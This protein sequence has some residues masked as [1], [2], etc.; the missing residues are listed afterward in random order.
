M[1]NY[2]KL[3]GIIMNSFE[4]L[5]IQ[6]IIGTTQHYYYYYYELLSNAMHYQEVAGI[7]VNSFE[8]ISI[9]KTANEF[10]LNSYG[11]FMN[12]YEFNRIHANS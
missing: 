8:F 2:Y 4:F 12:S 3:A 10:K 5:I 7:I 9:Y 11:F 6:Q 1:Q